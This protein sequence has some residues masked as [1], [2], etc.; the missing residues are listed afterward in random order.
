MDQSAKNNANLMGVQV[1]L[2]TA[3][4]ALIKTHPNPEALIAAMRMEHQESLALL[5]NMPIQDQTLEAFHV[6]WE[7]V[8]PKE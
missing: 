7:L 6:A 3:I 8:G 4:R 2:A 1:A 5:T